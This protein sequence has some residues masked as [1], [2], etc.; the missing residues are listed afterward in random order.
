MSYMKKLGVYSLIALALVASRGIGTTYS[1]PQFGAAF[2]GSF[3]GDFILVAILG[4][5]ALALRRK[6]QSPEKDQ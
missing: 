3:I 4:E 2:V 6:R 1:R 5:V